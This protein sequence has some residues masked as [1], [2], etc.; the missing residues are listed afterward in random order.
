MPAPL[1]QIIRRHPNLVF[2]LC[3]LTLFGLAQLTLGTRPSPIDSVE[4]LDAK[5]T[6]GQPVIIELYTNL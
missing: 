4:A 1:R 3:L 2:L 5:L 6:A